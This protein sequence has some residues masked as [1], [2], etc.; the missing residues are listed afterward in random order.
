MAGETRPGKARAVTGDAAFSATASRHGWLWWLAGGVFAVQ[1]LPRVF[2]YDKFL[3]GITYAAGARNMAAGW[4]SLWRPYVIGPPGQIFYESPPLHMWLESSVFR[5]FGDARNV[6]AVWPALMAVAIAVMIAWS[7]RRLAAGTS[8]RLDG[9][10]VLLWCLM[11]VNAWAFANNM[12]ETTMT[13]FIVVGVLAGAGAVGVGR[14]SAATLLCALCGVCSVAAVLTKGPV[15]LFPLSAPLLV[16][17]AGERRTHARAAL[18]TLGALTSAVVTGWL[19]VRMNPDASAFLRTYVDQQVAATLFV[20]RAIDT[21][22]LDFFKVVL[23]EIGVPA[24]VVLLSSLAAGLR[25]RRLSGSPQRLLLLM[26]VAATLPLLASPKQRR[27]YLVHSMPF[28]SLAIAMLALPLALRIRGRYGRSRRFRAAIIG[29]TL[30]T[31]GA[32]LTL[33]AAGAGTSRKNHTFFADFI[34]QQV[35][36]PARQPIT[37][38]PPS[39]VRRWLLVSEIQR[40]YRAYLVATPDAPFWLTVRDHACEPPAGCEP[41]QSKKPAEYLLFR[42]PGPMSERSQ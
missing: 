11:P 21:T 20:T 5:V 15:G 16:A 31:W 34:D 42:C 18:A 1:F 40:Y 23:E 9:W 39:L 41:V 37:V 12:P 25:W 32:A 30:L 19:V 26:A 2:S 29:L 4:G 13:T 35:E 14:L 7:W 24:L 28:W 17:L 36:L 27:W 6:E 38:C 33:T 10:P 22:R 3:D 8:R